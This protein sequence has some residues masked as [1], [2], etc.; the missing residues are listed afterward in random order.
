[1]ESRPTEFPAYSAA[2]MESRPTEFPAYS[3]GYGKPPYG[4]S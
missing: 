1:M 4:V 3:G 2:A